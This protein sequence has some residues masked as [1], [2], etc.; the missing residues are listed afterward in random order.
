MV[1]APTATAAQPRRIIRSMSTPAPTSGAI[2]FAMLDVPDE[3]A[4]RQPIET[5]MTAPESSRRVVFGPGVGHG[6]VPSLSISI[7]GPGVDVTA[8][9]SLIRV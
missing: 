4:I 1:N 5:T 7:S 3:K 8:T 9:H 6:I 2:A